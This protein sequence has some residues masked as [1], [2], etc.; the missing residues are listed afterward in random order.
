MIKLSVDVLQLLSV[1]V[2]FLFGLKQQG[3][4]CLDTQSA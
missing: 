2:R 4:K 1:Y 3:R